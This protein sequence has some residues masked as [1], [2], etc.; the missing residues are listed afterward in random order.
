MNNIK[1]PKPYA[2]GVQAYGFFNAKGK[3]NIGHGYATSAQNVPPIY[4]KNDSR[5]VRREWRYDIGQSATC[6]M[7]APV[8]TTVVL[9][10]DLLYGGCGVMTSA[11]DEPPPYS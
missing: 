4:R 9:I 6:C 5:I 10:I 11:G 2:C 1:I 8:P 3:I 7:D